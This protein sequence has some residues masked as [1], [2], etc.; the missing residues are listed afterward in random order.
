M[1]RCAVLSVVDHNI[2]FQDYQ[3]CSGIYTFAF[4]MF[5]LNIFI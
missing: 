1:M 2:E 4:E 3:A 5:S